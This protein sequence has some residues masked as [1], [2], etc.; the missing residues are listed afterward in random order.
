MEIQLQ[1]LEDYRYNS[2]IKEYDSYVLYNS[3][4]LNIIHITESINHVF[5]NETLYEFLYSNKVQGLLLV[6]EDK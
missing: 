2:Q 4:S 5:G 3:L 6:T 1:S